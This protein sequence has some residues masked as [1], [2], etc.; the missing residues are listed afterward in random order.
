MHPATP[1]DRADTPAL[2]WDIYCRVIDNLG[3]V[4]VCWRLA[5]DLAI[6]GQFVRLWTDDARPLAWMVP[7]AERASVKVLSW[8]TDAGESAQTPACADVVIEAFGC[9]LPISTL[10]ALA[11][12]HEQGRPARWINLEYLSAESHA[13]RNNGLPSP[14]LSGPARGLTKTFVFPGFE[15][16][17]A[18]LILE[19][20]LLPSRRAARHNEAKHAWRDQWGVGTHER[21]V[22]L[23]CY[24]PPGLPLLLHRLATSPEPVVLMV[25]AGR[26]Q[27]AL[28]QAWQQLGW[29][30]VDGH[31]RAVQDQSAPQSSLRY[32][33]LRCLNLPWLTQQGFDQLLWHADFNFVRGEDSLVR[34]LWAGQPFVWQAYRQDDGAHHAKVQ[35]LMDV[36]QAPT[37]VRQWHAWWNSDAVGSPFPEHKTWPW[38][39]PGWS[40]WLSSQVES[41]SGWCDLSQHL[42]RLVAS[43]P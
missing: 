16:G 40:A 18:G 31:L 33:N 28:A 12:R 8:P 27:Q 38:A 10:Q 9:D 2:L 15:P 3:D 11:Q 22:S 39:Q 35:A 25:T 36:L 6:R 21:A 14:V 29:P 23:F 20:G 1:A 4:G 30:C 17:T 43:D 34:A 5:R 37:E 41:L 13:K 42:L 19:P 26:A 24:E 7:P 32:Q